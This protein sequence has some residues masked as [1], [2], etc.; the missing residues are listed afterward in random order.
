M[1]LLEWNNPQV[2]SRAPSHSAPAEC[3]RFAAIPVRSAAT[4]GVLLLRRGP[5]RTVTVRWPV[6]A[7]QR[8]AALPENDID[9]SE[10]GASVRSADSVGA[11][12][13]QQRSSRA[14]PATTCGRRKGYTLITLRHDGQQ[15]TNTKKP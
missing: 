15:R 9:S 3:I 10:S 13:R 4:I 8:E 7:V 1:G 2:S 14:G 5:P 6:R 11:D 12:S